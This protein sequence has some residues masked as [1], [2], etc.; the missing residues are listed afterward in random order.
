MQIEHISGPFYQLVADWTMFPDGLRN[1]MEK[2]AEWS[3]WITAKTDYSSPGHSTAS[4]GYYEVD[5]DDV[6]A[7][8]S[9]LEISDD[10]FSCMIQSLGPMGDI[11]LK[12]TV[13]PII[14]PRG[15][16]YMNTEGRRGINSLLCFNTTELL[17]PTWNW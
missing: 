14:Y 16:I 7:L 11:W 6:V 17:P 13:T 4:V 10:G 3:K 5:G 8:M 15:A 9:D 12:E 2:E 1:L